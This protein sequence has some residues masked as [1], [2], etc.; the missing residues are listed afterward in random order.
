MSFCFEARRE[1]FYTSKLCVLK[2]SAGQLLTWSFLR[3]WSRV[4]TIS[5]NYFNDDPEL[6]FNVMTYCEQR[7]IEEIL[8]SLRNKQDKNGVPIAFLSNNLHESELEEILKFY[9]FLKNYLSSLNCRLTY[10]PE[11]LQN[12][13][14]YTDAAHL[15][16]GTRYSNQSDRSVFEKDLSVNGIP[17]LHIT[18]VPFSQRVVWK[19]QLI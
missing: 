10:D 3:K 14:N 4:N 7:P 12:P 5:E 8:L 15:M 6:S 1:R 11:Y 17:N 13:V 18:E 19:I 16:G 9:S 2:S